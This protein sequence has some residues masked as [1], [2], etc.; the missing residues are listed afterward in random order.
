MRALLHVGP[1]NYQVFVDCRR[2]GESVEIVRKLV[3]ERLAHV[4][5]SLVAESGHEL[6]RAGVQRNQPSVGA[7]VYDLRRPLRVPGPIGNSAQGR[8]VRAFV[9]PDLLS[10]FG[11]Q[12]QHP[13]I[14]GPHVQNAV[15]HQRR[16]FRSSL[17][18][19]AAGPP[20]RTGP[21][22]AAR[23]GACTPRAGRRRLRHRSFRVDGPSLL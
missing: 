11:L 15:N 20:G 22:R 16:A 5:H 8:V 2:R 17:S 12:R 3:V 6:A 19:A 9:F 21:T 1:G 18:R 13:V 7:C 14:T 23:R 10:G 4:H